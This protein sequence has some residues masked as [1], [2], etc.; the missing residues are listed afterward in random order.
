MNVPVYTENSTV[1]RIVEN[2]FKQCGTRLTVSQVEYGR[3]TAS[4]LD[5]ALPFLSIIDGSSI[6]VGFDAFIGNATQNLMHHRQ[7][8]ILIL[9]R[10]EFRHRQHYLKKYPFVI[11]ILKTD[12]VKECLG[13]VLALFDA[14]PHILMNLEIQALVSSSVTSKFVLLGIYRAV[15]SVCSAVLRLIERLGLIE[16]ES[17]EPTHLTLLELISNAIEHGN[18][19]ISFE[20]KRD[21]LVEHPDIYSLIEQKKDD[22]K[23]K[24]KYSTLEMSIFPTH[25]HFQ[26][27]DMGKGFDWRAFKKRISSAQKAPEQ[28]GYGIAMASTYASHITYNDA[29]NIVSFDMPLNEARIRREF[30]NYFMHNSP[31]ITLKKSE[32]LIS[33]GTDYSLQDDARKVYFIIDGAL[34]V[35]KDN[36]SIATMYADDV[37]CGEIGY[38][39][40]TERAVTLIAATV[41]RLIALD[42]DRFAH[43]MKDYDFCKMLLMRVLA[44]RLSTS[45]QRV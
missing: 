44:E 29:G 1:F 45:T 30:P 17:V 20:D 8:V 18:F 10:E 15:P 41:T 43:L 31:R 38:L 9:A 19:E 12:E 14:N 25:I 21:W 23:F 35:I 2:A 42:T 22:P 24:N 4:S 34:S 36:Q 3:G 27:T 32:L 39:M 37:F 33:E 26:I 7:V 28:H 40:Q 5:T 6:D 13:G 16:R 11:S